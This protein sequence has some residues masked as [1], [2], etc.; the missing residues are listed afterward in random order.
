MAKLLSKGTT[1]EFSTDD[2]TSSEVLTCQV[3]TMDG[4][5]QS[6]PITEAESLCL[7]PATKIPGGLTNDDVTI[8]G[9]FDPE[10]QAIVALQALMADPP[11]QAS[12]RVTWTDA[13]STV[14]QFTGYLT[15][16]STTTSTGSAVGLALTVSVDTL[17]WNQTP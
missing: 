17:V 16:F 5:G 13:S 8:D 11:T 12:Y 15:R 14:T 10:D 4:P 6:R 9:F 2:F 3:A 7:E 1:I